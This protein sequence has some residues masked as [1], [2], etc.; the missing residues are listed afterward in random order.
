MF[1]KIQVV[2]DLRLRHL[3]GQLNFCMIRYT[4]LVIY[5]LCHLPGHVNF[6]LIRYMWSVIYDCGI[7]LV[8]LTCV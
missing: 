8:V 3:P 7:Y 5:E 2:G 1:D 6:C 4:L